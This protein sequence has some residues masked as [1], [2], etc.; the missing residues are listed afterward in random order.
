[1]KIG[2]LTGFWSSGCFYFAIVC[3][4]HM[5]NLFMFVCAVQDLKPIL[6]GMSRSISTVMACRIVLQL[7]KQ[8]EKENAICAY[9]RTPALTSINAFGEFFELDADTLHPRSISATGR[10]RTLEHA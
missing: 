2:I 5:L 9:T 6:T 7:R 4:M 8:A 1:M 3:I 10:I